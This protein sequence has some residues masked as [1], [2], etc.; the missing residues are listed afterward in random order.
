MYIGTKGTKNTKFLIRRFRR[1]GRKKISRVDDV[2]AWQLC[3][4]CGACAYICPDEIEMIDT[5][6]YGR[7]PRFKDE[8]S[9]ARG[10]LAMKVCPGIELTRMAKPDDQLGDQ[11]F[12]DAW[13]P[14]LGVWEGYAADSQIRFEGSSGGAATALSLFALERLGMHRV[15]HVY[16]RQDVPY[17]NRTV[18][19]KTREELLAGTGSRYAPASPCDGLE[20]IEQA[21]GPCVFVGKPCDVAAF[22]KAAE[23]RPALQ[24]K[25]GLT[26][27]F[28]CA[29]TPSTR[30]TLEMM[31]QMGIADPTSV[32][33]LRYR[34]QGWP[35]PTMVAVK[36]PGGGEQRKELTYEQSWG[37][38][39]QKYRQWRCHICPDHVGEFADI[40]VAD[41]WHR[42]VSENQPGLSVMVARTMRGKEILER[43]IHKGC[44]EAEAVSPE[45]LPLCRPDQ[46]AHQGGLWARVQTLK[47]MR[48][49]T[50]EFRH[51]SLF[52]LWISDLSVLAKIRS[53][54]STIKRV[55]V[56]HLYHRHNQT[57]LV[58]QQKDKGN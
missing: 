26:I 17:L 57:P 51:F 55:Y 44:I 32:V 11:R 16:S 6:E 24:E 40:A 10:A 58:V 19:S 45:I 43:A 23:L 21:A 13:G 48:V 53:I 7:R 1:V 22:G 33:S 15:L 50:P 56:K 54:L 39:L 2:A 3:C 29:G 9:A 18:L 14:V 31:R 28:F 27:A 30:G 8:A 46:A 20:L 49:P 38:I 12:F 35:G 42:P 52:R 5:L 25:I 34:G 41:A 36:A 47:A 37:E 4:G